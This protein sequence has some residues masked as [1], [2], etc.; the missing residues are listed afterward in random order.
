MNSTLE[1]T[2]INER[3]LSLKER[4]RIKNLKHKDKEAISIYTQQPKKEEFK[5]KIR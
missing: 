5:D 3:P 2:F 4:I 1:S